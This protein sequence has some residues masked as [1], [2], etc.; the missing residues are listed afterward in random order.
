MKIYL[1]QVGNHVSQLA[2]KTLEEAQAFVETRVANKERINKAN[3]YY[4]EVGRDG[5][6]YTIIDVVV[7]GVRSE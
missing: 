4:S 7:E 5:Q 2:Y 6:F 3:P 1:V